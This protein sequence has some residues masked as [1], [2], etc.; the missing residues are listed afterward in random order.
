MTRADGA[1]LVARRR[2]AGIGLCR[3]KTLRMA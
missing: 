1:S 3:A 2:P